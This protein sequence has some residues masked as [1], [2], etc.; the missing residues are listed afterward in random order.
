[1]STSSSSTLP[2]TQPPSDSSCMRFRQRRNVLLPQPE[3]PMMAVTVWAGKRIET[4]RTA[5]VRLKSAVRR[6]VSSR[7]RT[8]ADATI[9]LP[10]H[11]A[12]D[13][14]EDEHEGYEQQRR[15]PREAVPILVG[16]GPVHVDLERQRLHRWP[17]AGHEVEIAERGEQERRRFARDPGDPDEATGD[18]PAQGGTRHDAQRRAPA[19]VPEREG[20]L[21]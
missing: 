9:A 18:D 21:T 7:R 8:L 2:V 16:P 14:G 13:H 1:M 15:G 3:G 11:P 4:S 17:Q 19:R 5:A 6:T 10:R 20:R 12:G